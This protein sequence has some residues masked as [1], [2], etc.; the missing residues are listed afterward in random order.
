MR[1]VIIDD[2][3]GV[4]LGTHRLPVSYGSF[5]IFRIFSENDMYGISRA[6]SFD[7]K[8]EAF[9]YMQSFLLKDYPHCR[10]VEIPGDGK[11]VDVVDLIKAGYGRYTEGMWDSLPMAND[12]IH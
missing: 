7:N 6:F 5:R 11:Y 9:N 2:K 3:M 4:F 12:T 1:Y 8:K 10:I